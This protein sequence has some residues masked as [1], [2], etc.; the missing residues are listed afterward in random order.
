MGGWCCLVARYRADAR[1][2]RHERR[3]T[4]NLA[5]QRTATTCPCPNP[6]PNPGPGRATRTAEEEARRRAADCGP[7][8]C[9]IPHSCS[10]GVYESG[11]E[12]VVN[13]A[14]RDTKRA[15][16]PNGR[17]LATV[18]QAIDRHLRHAHE[19][20][21]LGDGDEPYLRQLAIHGHRAP[22][23][24]HATQCRL[25]PT[26]LHVPCKSNDRG[27]SDSW[28]SDCSQDLEI[29]QPTR[30][31]PEPKWKRAC[32]SVEPDAEAVT[33]EDSLPGGHH[34]TVHR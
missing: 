32:A 9:S 8:S 34:R 18:H 25:P 14:L 15:P 6:C 29:V 12:V 19:R 5:R 17:E 10:S 27:R 7:P 20:G 31:R 22:R 1:C 4:P 28:G 33:G 2:H 16:D 21:N 30:R 13:R 3:S 23:S 26:D 11:P 24:L